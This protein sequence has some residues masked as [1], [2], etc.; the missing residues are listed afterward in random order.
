[1]RIYYLAGVILS[2]TATLSACGEGTPKECTISTTRELRQGVTKVAK[3]APD[4]DCEA[5]RMLAE[6]GQPLPTIASDTITTIAPKVAAT[7]TPAA[8]NTPFIGGQKTQELIAITN[9]QARVQEL[10]QKINANS[11]QSRDPFTSTVINPVPKLE[12]LLAKPKEL[13]NLRAAV[14]VRT[15]TRSAFIAPPPP[16]PTF[17]VV[18]RPY[19]ETG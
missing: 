18:P 13:P 2:V 7:P 11:K 15:S 10:E 9:K 8:F 12:T 16:P 5:M 6:Q 19:R 14:V 4:K 3:F 17:A 1:M